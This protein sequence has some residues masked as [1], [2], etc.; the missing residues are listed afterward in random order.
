MGMAQIGGQLGQPPLYILA[1]RVPVHQRAN[2]EGVAEVVDRGP[3]RSPGR[4]RP[5]SLVQ[6]M[7]VLWALEWLSLAPRSPV[8]KKALARRVA[9]Q[10][11]SSA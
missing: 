11:R 6:S 2:G 4:L 5:A 7:N 3:D 8:K 1:G 10:S 9:Q